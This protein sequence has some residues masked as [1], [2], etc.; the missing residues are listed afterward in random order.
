LAE[1]LHMTTTAEG[2][3]TEDQLLRLRAEG[4]TQGQGYLFSRPLPVDELREFLRRHGYAV[5]AELAEQPT[6]AR[7]SLPEIR[8]LRVTKKSTGRRA[9]DPAAKLG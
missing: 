9:E 3:E 2:V 5:T 7:H 4:C 1:S 6:T 8:D